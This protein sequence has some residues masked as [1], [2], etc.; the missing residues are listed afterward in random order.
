[1]TIPKKVCDECEA[2]EAKGW[3]PDAIKAAGL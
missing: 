3:M 1:L 2:L